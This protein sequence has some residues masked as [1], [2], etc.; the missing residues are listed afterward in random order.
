MEIDH[1]LMG[2]KGKGGGGGMKGEFWVSR[3]K[4]L[5]IEW[6]NNKILLYITG[7]C[8]QYPVINHKEKIEKRMYIYVSIYLYIESLCCTA[9]INT[10][11]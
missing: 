3:S 1:R 5:Y 9:E 10:T 11:L 7:N 2:A 6:I 8:I 4:L